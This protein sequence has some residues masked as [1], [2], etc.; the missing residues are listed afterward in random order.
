MRPT[1]LVAKTHVQ[2]LFKT[3][4]SGFEDCYNSLTLKL[5]FISILFTTSYRSLFSW[6]AKIFPIVLARAS[7]SRVYI[8]SSG[9][10]FLGTGEKIRE[11]TTNQDNG[12]EA[13]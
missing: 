6:W 12:Q 13:L 10:L 8:T 2:S 7:F 1:Q 11:K 9:Q 5:A 3:S 4:R